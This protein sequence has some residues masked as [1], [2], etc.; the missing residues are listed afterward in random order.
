MDLTQV[1][2]SKTEWE[3][4]ESPVSD[5]EKKI[6]KVIMEGFNNINIKYNDN[7]SMLQLLKVNSS[8]IQSLEGYFYKEYFLSR[9]NE[10]IQ[11]IK[12]TSSNSKSVKTSNSKSSKSSKKENTSSSTTPFIQSIEDWKT[13]NNPSETLKKIK[14]C[15]ILRIGNVS[16]NIEKMKSRIYEFILLDLCENV[17]VS[18]NINTKN[19][20]NYGFDLYTLIQLKK[21]NIQHLN[22]YVMKFVEFTVETA[23]THTNISHIFSNAYEFIEKNTHILKYDD[24]SLFTHQKKLFSIFNKPTDRTR[25]SEEYPSRLILYMAPTGTGKTLSPIGLSNKYKIIFVCVARHVGLALA[26]SAISIGKKVAFAFGCDTASDIRLHYYA[27]VSYSVNTKTGGIY[28][29]DNSVGTNVEIMI[30]DVKS[31]L[32]AMYY[33]LAFNERENII[34][35]WDEPTIT[36]DYESHPLHETIHRN[37]VEN[38]IPNVIL[39]CATLPKEEEILDTIMDFKSTFENAEI[40]T[41]TSYECKK[42]ISLI[43]KEGKCCLPHL[44]FSNYEELKECIQYCNENKSLLRYFDLKEIIRFIEYMDKS[45]YIPES[46]RIPNYFKTIYDIHMNSIKLYY[47]IILSHIDPAYWSIIYT[48]I[49]NSQEGK[50]AAE[51]LRKIKSVDM[52]SVYGSKSHI[53]NT[54]TNSVLVRTTS[55]AGGPPYTPSTVTASTS[56]IMITTSDAHTLTDG[57]TIYIADDVEK[58]G[59]FCIQQAKIP[60]RVFQDIVDKIKENDVILKKIQSIERS[61]EDS[62]GADLEKERKMEKDNNRQVNASMNMIHE[63]QNQIKYVNMD[64]K[65]IPNTKPHQQLWAPNGEF[66]GNAFMPNIEDGVVREIMGIQID[67]HMKLLLL[68]GIGVFVNQ[69]NTQYMEIMKKLA[70]EQKLYIII[71][72]SD[73]IYGTNYQFCH[74]FIGKDLTNMTQQKTI[75]AIGRIGRSNIQQEYTVRFRDDSILMNLFKPMTENMEA[76]NMVRLFCR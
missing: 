12:P 56:G 46:Y 4:I 63:L 9:I 10:I 33:M 52:A 17:F 24:I 23:I 65:Y 31:Y 45:G 19:P 5:N 16:D 70:S 14:K 76:V 15:D 71:A 25:S 66:I 67:S 69:P 47:L 36:M 60:D 21:Y 41:I 11:K 6:L 61:L 1:K 74:G 18:L 29:V 7:L 68:M 59:K 20:P 2:L 49:S 57:P 44:L 55:V 37:W 75:Q 13:A 40:H 43:N 26:K 35:Y 53:A 38:K 27:A 73:Y 51:T 48:H 58:I 50:F 34:T 39:S 72:Q 64:L 32:T 8:D 30:C 54:N 28:K 3:T 62:L 22:T 42:S